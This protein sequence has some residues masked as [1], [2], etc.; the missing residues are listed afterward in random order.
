MAD[1]RTQA[2]NTPLDKL[3]DDQK[4]AL[5]KPAEKAV[6]TP[7]SVKQAPRA[8][9]TPQAEAKDEPKQDESKDESKQEGPSGPEDTYQ[10][11]ITALTA[12]PAFKVTTQEDKAPEPPEDTY[13]PDITALGAGQEAMQEESRKVAEGEQEPSPTV[14]AQF[15]ADE[16]NDTVPAQSK[17]QKK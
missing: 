4:A 9:A 15:E 16:D 11:D 1:E 7:K 6:P 10:P 14:P 8:S 2:E 17:S 3:T 5:N 13:Q 12:A